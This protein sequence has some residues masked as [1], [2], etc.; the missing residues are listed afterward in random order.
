MPKST[1]ARE[2]PVPDQPRLEQSFPELPS[3]G[4]DPRLQNTT[5]KAWKTSLEPVGGCARIEQLNP[6]EKLVA[7]Q[8]L[9][10][11]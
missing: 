5:R 3:Q 2:S 8:E 7:L 9:R 1:Q 10:S 6:T 4:V 11:V